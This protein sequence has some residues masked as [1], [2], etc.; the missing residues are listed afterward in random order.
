M[1]LVTALALGLVVPSHVPDTDSDEDVPPSAQ[2]PN[3]IPT[4]QAEMAQT[5]GPV[6]SASGFLDFFCYSH[7]GTNSLRFYI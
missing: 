1:P 6:D 4:V 7:R 2:D 5:T 3:S